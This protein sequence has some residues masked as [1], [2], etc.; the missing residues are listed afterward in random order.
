MCNIIAFNTTVSETQE[1]IKQ[2]RWLFKIKRFRYGYYLK[3][4]QKVCNQGDIVM[5]QSNY[6]FESNSNILFV[7]H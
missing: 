4:N 1:G 7:D 2:S 6:L 5:K 3:K